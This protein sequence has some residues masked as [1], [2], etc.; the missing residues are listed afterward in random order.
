MQFRS[1]ADVDA[2]PHLDAL[3]DS[4]MDACSDLDANAGASP[5]AHP[6]AGAYGDDRR[7]TNAH[8]NP[9]ATCADFAQI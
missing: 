4:N 9:G 3:A 1:A 5:N 6:G 8:G 7:A 2:R